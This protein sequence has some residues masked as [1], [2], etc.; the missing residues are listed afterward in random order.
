MNKS[1]SHTN[2]LPKRFCY[3]LRTNLTFVCSGHPHRAGSSHCTGINMGGN[4]LL[5]LW[6]LDSSRQFLFPPT[7]GQSQQYPAKNLVQQSAA[8][9]SGDQAEWCL[10]PQQAAPLTMHR[11]QL[12]QA[13]TPSHQSWEGP[14]YHSEQVSGEKPSPRSWR[15]R[16]SFASSPKEFQATF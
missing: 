3:V 10:N 1:T 6:E 14:D 16:A 2:N 12:K 11:P 15:C 7:Y 5:F 4:W 13:S 8:V 9:R